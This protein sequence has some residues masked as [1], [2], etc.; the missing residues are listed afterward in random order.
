VKNKEC[1]IKPAYFLA[2]VATL[3]GPASAWAEHAL[4]NLRVFRVDPQTKVEKDEATAHADHEPPQGGSDPR[5]VFK[6]QVNEPLVAQFF[7]TNTYPHAVR[8]AVTVRYYV[9]REQKAGQKNV[10][11]LS[12]GTVIQ[13]SFL[14]DFK[15][16]GKVGA[17]V[18][19][20]CKEPG[21]YLLRVQSENTQSDHEHF[22]AIDIEVK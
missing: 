4:I 16:Q 3:L 21:T 10:P 18:R 6:A 1:F 14:L 5:P 9:V 17:R 7:F 13:G 20:S 19:F 11:D 15:P 12:T 22:A 2:L 8:K